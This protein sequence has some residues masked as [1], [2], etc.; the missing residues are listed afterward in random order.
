LTATD[1]G[2][3]TASSRRFQDGASTQLLLF[4]FLTSLNGAIWLI[5]T[6]RL[7][8]GRRVLSTPNLRAYARRG[9]AAT[10]RTPAYFAAIESGA[11]LIAT[12][13]KRG[14]H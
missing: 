6:R 11:S 4:I 14:T 7:G 2:K 10:V 1:G 9:T 3:Y 5:E 12:A 8:V 13:G